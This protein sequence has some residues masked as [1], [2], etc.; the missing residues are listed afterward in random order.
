MIFSPPLVC[1][2]IFYD[3]VKKKKEIKGAAASW[4]CYQYLTYAISLIKNWETWTY[5]IYQQ[6]IVFHLRVNNFLDDI[7][8]NT[9]GRFHQLLTFQDKREPKNGTECTQQISGVKPINLIW[10]TLFPVV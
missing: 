6:K 7:S 3:Q 5:T 10:D 4:V 8:T 2:T 1:G 9:I